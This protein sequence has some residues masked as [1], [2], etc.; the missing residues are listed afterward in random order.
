MQRFFLIAVSG[1]FLGVCSQSVLDANAQATLESS[2]HPLYENRAYGF[3]VRLPRGVTYTRTVPPSPDHGIGI[4]LQEQGRLWVDA[5]YTDSLSTDDEATILSA[6]CRV[7]K[8]QPSMLG[9]QPALVLRFS[10]PANG[11]AYEELL[12]LT[13]HKQGDRSLADYQIGLRTDA[14]GM[15][16]NR[17]LF[18]EIVAGFSFQ[19]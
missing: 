16:K 1:V 3:R 8:R 6:G 10:C 19:R 18:D 7:Q 11:R 14:S 2:A 4:T 5:S 13:V 17:R 9:N 15:L 12:V